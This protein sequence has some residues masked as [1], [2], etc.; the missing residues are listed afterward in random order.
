LQVIKY[1]PIFTYRAE[2]DVLA[3][4][5]N[6]WIVNLNFSFQDNNNLYL[7]ME[8]LAGGDLMSLLIKRD[9]FTEKEA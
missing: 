2:R 9:I 7:V 5:N 1:K 6:P 3:N 4:S 8:Y